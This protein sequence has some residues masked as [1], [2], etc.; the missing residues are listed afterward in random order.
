MNGCFIKKGE[1]AVRTDLILN[2]DIPVT[3]V[4]SAE[5]GNP[6]PLFRSGRCRDVRRGH[7][8][9]RD[10]SGCGAGEVPYTT[11]DL[12]GRNLYFAED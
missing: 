6:S 10:D 2:I 12:T 9:R 3:G 11:G 1:G 7:S 5:R 8:L 4:Q